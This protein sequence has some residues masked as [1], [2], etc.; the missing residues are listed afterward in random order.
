MS[1]EKDV[2][3]DFVAW[4][5]TE[6]E[7]RMVLVEQGPW[8]ESIDIE[9]RRLQNRLYEC[10]DAAIDGKLAIKFP[11][12]IGKR[13]IIQIDCYNVPIIEVK[14]F[15]DRFSNGVF[16]LA[17]YSEA[18]KNSKFVSNIGFEINFNDI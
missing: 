2:L 16:K 3:V 5:D 17:D 15:F 7:W 11:K 12:T 9:L 14:E 13:I 10:M 1:D 8:S 6:D 18:I 4:T